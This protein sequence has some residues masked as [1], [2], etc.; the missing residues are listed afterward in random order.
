MAQRKQNQLVSMRM[1]VQSLASISGSGNPRCHELWCRSQMWLKSPV[2]VA[3]VSAGSCSSNSA[4]S[5][6]TSMCRRC[7]PK[8]QRKRKKEIV[9]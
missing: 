8:K 2:A 9:S 5:L 1:Q 6:G 3:V 7:G 4:P